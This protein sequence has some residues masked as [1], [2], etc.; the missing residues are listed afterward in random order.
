M[1]SMSVAGGS[2]FSTCASAMPG[3]AELGARKPIGRQRSNCLAKPHAKFTA[4][5]KV[6]LKFAHR[7]SSYIGSAKN[8]QTQSLN[9]MNYYHSSS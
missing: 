5:K 9:Q 1:A 8:T 7:S 6:G 4:T 3:G 2:A